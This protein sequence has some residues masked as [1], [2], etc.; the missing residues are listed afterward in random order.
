[1]FKE[2]G[3][4]EECCHHY[5]RDSPSDGRNTP[6]PT[7]THEPCSY[8]CNSCDRYPSEIE[9]V[10]R[11]SNIFVEPIH[12]PS[13]SLDTSVEDYECREESEH[14]NDWESDVLVLPGENP[15]TIQETR[16]SIEVANIFFYKFIF[17]SLSSKVIHEWCN[18]KYEKEGVDNAPNRKR[19]TNRCKQI[20]VF[21]WEFL[22]CLATK[23]DDNRE[24]IECH[25]KNIGDQVEKR[26]F[27]TQMIDEKKGMQSIP[28][29]PSFPRRRESR[30][31]KNIYT[32]QMFDF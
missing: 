7:D 10:G 6:T 30:P 28:L 2:Y 13:I 26:E 12:S 18:W 14:D 25:H 16:D 17:L 29:S 3:C 11:A 9:R 5:H 1:M 32:N 20:I 8:V 4:T 21:I 19:E 22:S 15:E 24:S 23:R 27:H 31:K